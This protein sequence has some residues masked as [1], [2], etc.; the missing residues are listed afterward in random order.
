MHMNETHA[1]RIT[2]SLRDFAA[3]SYLEYISEL[4]L[5]EITEDDLLLAVEI[6]NSA[7]NDDLCRIIIDHFLDPEEIPHC[8]TNDEVS[9]LIS[10]Y[11]RRVTNDPTL[12][13]RYFE[14]LMFSNDSSITFDNATTKIAK[15]TN[16]DLYEFEPVLD[17]QTIGYFLA[18]N[19]SIIEI[20]QDAEENTIL[21]TL[22]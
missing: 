19:P 12:T 6:H 3:H 21:V 22:D 13:R 2:R 5:D 10:D 14:F 7:F 16:L 20:Y 15:P 1:R 4:E 11:H 8:S 17:Y 9:R 18:L